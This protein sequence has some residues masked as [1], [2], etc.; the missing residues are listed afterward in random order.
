[1]ANFDMAWEY[2]QGPKDKG[3]RRTSSKKVALGEFASKVDAG[4]RH[5]EIWIVT[6]DLLVRFTTENGPLEL[7]AS[8]WEGLA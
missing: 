5:D 6:T 4:S 8:T 2:H 1:M 3:K 7:G